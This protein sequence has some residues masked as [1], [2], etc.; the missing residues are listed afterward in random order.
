MSLV[1]SG[2]LAERAGIETGSWNR[3]TKSVV[4][5]FPWKPNSG[6]NEDS[7]DMDDAKIIE[8]Q[9]PN[10]ASAFICVW[11]LLRSF[12]LRRSRQVYGSLTFPLLLLDT[13][14]LRALSL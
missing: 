13:L 1:I 8:V 3:L 2:E 4:A 10:G 5:W 7:G 6:H 11:G 14:L 12:Y 9:A